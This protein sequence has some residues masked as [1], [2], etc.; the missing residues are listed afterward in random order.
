MAAIYFRLQ[1]ILMKSFMTKIITFQRMKGGL[2]TAY[3][4]RTPEFTL[5]V[6]GV[7]VAQSYLSVVVLSSFFLAI[8]LSVVLFSASGY[9]ASI[10]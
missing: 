10:L 4:S 8:G 7:H 1:V 3:P 9:P 2:G 6:S 5:V